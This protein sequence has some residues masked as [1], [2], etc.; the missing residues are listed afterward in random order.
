MFGAKV[1]LNGLLTVGISLFSTFSELVVFC[2]VMS[3]L[4]NYK[5]TISDF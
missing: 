2:G 3:A 4:D 5:Y 1:L